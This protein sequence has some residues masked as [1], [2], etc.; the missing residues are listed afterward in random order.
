MKVKVVLLGLVLI[1]I[2]SYNNDKSNPQLA[3]TYFLDKPY[4][5]GLKN[6]L[7]FVCDGTSVLKIFDRT[8]PYRCYNA[9]SVFRYPFK[10]FDSFRKYTFNV[11]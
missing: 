2:W 7:L 9:N 6:N 11:R 5:L 10:R 4:G 8:N 3:T 1:T